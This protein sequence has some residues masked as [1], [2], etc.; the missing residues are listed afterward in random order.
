[1]AE[2]MYE[3]LSLP[4]K[5]DTMAKIILQALSSYRKFNSVTL[6][7]YKQIKNSYSK[8]DPYIKQN[9][10]ISVVEEQ[11]YTFKKLD[12]KSELL[13]RAR[14]NLI[15]KNTHN[16][17]IQNYIDKEINKLKGLED[18]NFYI[19]TKCIDQN[20]DDSKAEDITI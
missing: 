7:L 16:I 18:L 12:N 8:G 10:D 11:L 6:D 1:S 20:D 5:S 3:M 13:K 9:Y 15:K 2:F 4:T 14:A 19:T 17:I